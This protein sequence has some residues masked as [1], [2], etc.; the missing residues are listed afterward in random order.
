[1]S[2][3]T[4]K[5]RSKCIDLPRE[6][7]YKACIFTDHCRLSSKYKLDPK[8]CKL[9]K[10]TKYSIPQSFKLPPKESKTETQSYSPEINRALVQ[11]RYSAKYDVF[12]AITNCMDIEVEQYKM[13][14]SILK[15][16]INPK[17]QL[18]N[19]LCVSYWNKEAQ[20]LFLDN[21]SKHH[22]IDINSLIVPKQSY[23]NCWFNTGFMMNYISDKGRKFN[24]YFRQYMITGKMKGFRPFLKQLKAPLFLFN[25]AIEATLQG[26]PLAKIMNTNDIIEKIH[27]QIPKT[28]KPNITKKKEYGNPY[29]YQMSLLNYL[30]DYTYNFTNGYRLY[31]SVHQNGYVNSNNDIIWAELDQTHSQKVNNKDTYLIDQNKHKYALDS[32]L[33]RDTEKTHFCCLLTINGKEYM[34]DGASSPSLVPMNWKNKTFLNG[35]SIFFIEPNSVKWDMR[36]GYQV[37]NYYR[38]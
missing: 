28:Y 34:Y 30:S 36:N 27:E 25:M 31:E 17:V 29:V 33:I 23:Y 22:S 3:K 21:L 8:T 15:Y 4:K 1:M 32:L 14:D 24:K 9:R 20:K 7:C 11:S 13:K 35:H 5:C 10:R 26:H 38:I 18:K 6:K 19:G 37:L 16:Y 12:T 2:N